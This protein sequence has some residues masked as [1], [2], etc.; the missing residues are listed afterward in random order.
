[1]PLGGNAPEK[2]R[3]A[4]STKTTAVLQQEGLVHGLAGL[5]G[6]AGV[7]EVEGLHK[8]A[9]GFA[10]GEHGRILAYELEV[11][12]VRVGGEVG[13]ATAEGRG[14]YFAGGERGGDGRLW[15]ILIRVVGFAAG[16]G[17][18]VGVGGVRGVEELRLKG[19]FFCGFGDLAGVKWGFEHGGVG[20]SVVEKLIKK[21]G[22]PFGHS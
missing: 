5:L 22:N 19:G 1:M 17:G 21:A 7:L 8:E 20:A 10:L 14:L 3:H 2:E 12:L 18:G 4:I 11:G 16:G 6:L 13:E 9:V 15:R